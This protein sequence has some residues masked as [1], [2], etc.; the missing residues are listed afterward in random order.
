MNNDFF[1]QKSTQ[2]I[3]CC[4]EISFEESFMKEHEAVFKK[5]LQKI[6]EFLGISHQQPNIQ[7]EDYLNGM[8]E[9]QAFTLRKQLQDYD[10]LS[11]FLD[12]VVK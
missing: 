6:M 3:A 5:A 1:Y 7:L 4:Y 2:D 10:K 9:Q 11:G 8:E 12:I